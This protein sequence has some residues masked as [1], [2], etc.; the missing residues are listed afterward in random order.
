MEINQELASL[1]KLS[2]L[3]NVDWKSMLDNFSNIGSHFSKEN[4]QEE[5]DN[6]YRMDVSLASAGAA[7]VVNAILANS[8]F[9]GTMMDK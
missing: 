2:E 9:N 3:A 8:N 6:L 7:I 5:I 1:L 4:L